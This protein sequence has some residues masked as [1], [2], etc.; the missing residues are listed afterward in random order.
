MGKN[1]SVMSRFRLSSSPARKLPSWPEL[2]P[3]IKRSDDMTV[4]SI[5]VFSCIDKDPQELV[6]AGLDRKYHQRYGTHLP[7]ITLDR[8]NIEVGTAILKAF[9]K[10]PVFREF[11]Y[12]MFKPCL[13]EDIRGLRTEIF[14]QE[15]VFQDF[16]FSWINWR[17]NKDMKLEAAKWY[18]WLACSLDPREKEMQETILSYA[19]EPMS[20]FTTKVQDFREVV[21]G[22]RHRRRRRKSHERKKVK[23]F[24]F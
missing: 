16:F 21:G 9:E 11:L 18:L 17:R 3:R 5:A 12:E 14:K 8:P 1:T 22:G 24:K 15:E 4:T 2:D 23:P 7:P 20:I 6:L 10:V 13:R 19:R